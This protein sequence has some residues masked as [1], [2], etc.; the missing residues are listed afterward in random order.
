MGNQ[1]EREEILRL[2]QKCLDMGTGK[3]PEVKWLSEVYDRFRRK[4]GMLS[5]AEADQLLCE[6]MGR[7]C[8]SLNVRYWRTGKHLPVNR[9]QCLAFG[10]ALELTEPEMRVLIQEYYDRSETVYSEI[11][12]EEDLFYWER[13]ERMEDLQREYLTKVRPELF[14]RNNSTWES[15]KRNFRHLYYVDASRYTI[16]GER[17]GYEDRSV[18]MNYYSE[19]NRVLCLQGEIPRKTMIRHLMILCVPYLSIQRMD[20]YLKLFG[21]LPLTEEH[22]QAGGEYLDWLLIRVLELYGKR[23]RGKEPEECTQWLQSSCRLLDQFF[24]ERGER[25]LRFMDFK[26]LKN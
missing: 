6:R 10:R 2:A 20:E 17:W 25:R 26:A 8:G 18:S 1:R 12:G 13:R 4:Q 21:Y 23:C 11:P 14:F 7:T 16:A 19:L 22:T 24:A 5:K 15:Q 9:E 3:R